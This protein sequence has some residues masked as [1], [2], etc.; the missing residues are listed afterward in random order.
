MSLLLFRQLFYIAP[1]PLANT[2]IV[3]F[4]QKK[5]PVKNRGDSPNN[6]KAPQ[7]FVASTNE[8]LG[9]DKYKQQFQ[10]TVCISLPWKETRYI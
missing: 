3:F 10:R 7:K 8:G 2:T 1:Y 4:R 6:G 9:I 5:A